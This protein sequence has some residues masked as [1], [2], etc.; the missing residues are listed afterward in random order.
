MLISVV[1]SSFD[2]C[3][4]FFVDFEVHVSLYNRLNEGCETTLKGQ[5]SLKKDGTEEEKTLPP[6]F[7]FAAN[8]MMFYLQV[9]TSLKYCT[10]YL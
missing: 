10:S 8:P 7:V 1:E 9:I 3:T 6:V 4:C 5:A 2:S